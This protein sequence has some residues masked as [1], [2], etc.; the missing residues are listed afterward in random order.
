MSENFDEVIDRA[1]DFQE[2]L[3]RRQLKQEDIDRLREKVQGLKY[4][5]KDVHEKQVN[6]FNMVLNDDIYFKNF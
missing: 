4:V 2:A 3:K 1:F 5:P 6:Y